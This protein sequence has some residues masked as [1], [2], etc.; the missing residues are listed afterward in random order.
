MRRSG[1]D[2]SGT[3]EYFLIET[4]AL[5]SRSNNN[6]LFVADANSI[7]NNGVSG[8]DFQGPIEYLDSEEWLDYIYQNDVYV[9]DCGDSG[10]L[11]LTM[12][13]N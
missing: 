3:G 2:A 11:G 7:L 9:I 12:F 10:M 5:S 1:R 6:S 8:T 4:T 13:A